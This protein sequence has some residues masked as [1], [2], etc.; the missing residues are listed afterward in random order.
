MKVTLKVIFWNVLI[1]IVSVGAVA[2]FSHH[3]PSDRL[4]YLLT[5]QVSTLIAAYFL[6]CL[7]AGFFFSFRKHAAL[8]NGFF[9]SAFTVLL[10]GIPSCYADV[11]LENYMLKQ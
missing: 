5:L 4:P 11:F 3:I 1:F 8:A 9:L 7:I 6:F 10:L 2:F